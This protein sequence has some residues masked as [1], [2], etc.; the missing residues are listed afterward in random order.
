MKRSFIF[1]VFIFLALNLFN[2]VFAEDI[3]FEITVDRN[4]VS[5]GE[6]FQMSFTFY[7]IQNVPAFE[8]PEVEEFESN[9]LGPFKRMSVVNGKVT[10]YAAH[11]YRLSPLK[12]GVFTIGPFSGEYK[13][14]VYSSNSIKIEVVDALGGGKGQGQEPDGGQVELRD[15]VFLVMKPEKT[16]VYLNEIVPLTIKLYVNTFDV[17]DVQYPRFVH[18]GFSVGEYEK[19]NQY[20]EVLAKVNFIMGVGGS[21]D[22]IA[23]KVPG[24]TSPDEIIIYDATGTAIQDAAGAALCY[25]KAVSIGKGFVFNFFK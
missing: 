10:N 9:Y 1:S 6:S 3:K 5:L 23:G 21:F 18:E 2:A 22:V 24:R 12:K 25:E 4:K 8:F 7:N 20:K 13:G 11:N 16:K 14:Q 19:A 15:K 17:R